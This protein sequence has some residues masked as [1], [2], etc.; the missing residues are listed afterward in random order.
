MYFTYIYNLTTFH[1]DAYSINGACSF[2][3]RNEVTKTIKPVSI[4]L[5]NQGGYGCS[6]PHFVLNTN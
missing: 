5:T 3:L 4:K 1:E 2:K 6:I